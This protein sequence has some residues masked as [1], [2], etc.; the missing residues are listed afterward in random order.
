MEEFNVSTNIIRDQDIAIQY[1]PTENARANF[2]LIASNYKNN[3]KFQGIIG[4]YGTG[5]SSFL[6]AF[7]QNLLG[8]KKYFNSINSSY[9]E[10]N[11]FQFIKLIGEYRSLSISLANTLKIKY[12]EN[13]AEN[14]EDE[15]IDKL[16]RI[17]KKN[18]K[19]N[20][21]TV[22][23]LDE[24][25][26]F[27]EFAVKNNPDKEVY[28]IQ[29]L[30]E[31]F[32]DPNKLALSI[33]SLH[34]NF[35]SYGQTLNVE[36]FKEWEKVKGRFKEVPFNEPID[37]LLDFASKR[38]EFKDLKLEDNSLQLFKLLK[39]HTVSDKKKKIDFSLAEELLPLDYI[40]AEIMAKS[41]QRYGQN[42]RSLFSFLDIDER[43][44]FKWFYNKSRN[45]K[46]IPEAYNL[47]L[48]FDYIFEHYYFVIAS[49]SNTDLTHW[50]AIKSALDQVDTRLGE[51][52]ILYGRQIVK[53][54]G[55]LNIFTHS[56]ANIDREFISS[57][58]KLALGINFPDEIIDTLVN[59]KI[60][61]YKNYKHRFVFTD[62]TDLDIDNELQKAAIKIED[63]KNVAERVSGLDNFYPILV[64]SHYFKSGTPRVFEYQ[65]TNTMIQEI[66]LESDALIN[67]V[68]SEEKINI[69]K[70]TKPV[71]YAVF[72]NTA[73]I[74]SLFYEID[75]AKKVKED[76]R[77]DRSAIRE[78]E[79]RIF[80]NEQELKDLLIEDVFS[81]NNIQ[82]YYQG[83]QIS[84]ENKSQFNKQLN[85]VLEDHYKK[86]PIFRSE[87]VNKSKLS[88]PISTARKNLIRE[89]IANRDKE[90][91]GF[92]DDKFPPEKTIYLSLIRSL[93]LHRLNNET[94]L[95][96]LGAPDF[97]TKNKLINSFKPLWDISM[98]F[99]EKSKTSK[100]NVKDFYEA[101]S[102]PPLKLKR[103]FIDFWVPI[104]LIVKKEDYALFNENGYIPNIDTEVFDV[105]YKSPQKFW[106]KA[107]D[108]SGVKLEV[109]N[110]YK[111]ILNRKK[112]EKASEQDFINTIKPF[113]IFTRTLNYYASNTKKLTQQSIDL[114]EAIKNAKD[115][116]KAFFEDFPKA[117]NYEEALQ[118]G[119]EKMLE[120]FVK[121][122]E[123]SI[124]EI[125][126]S[127]GELLTRFEDKINDVLSEKNNDFKKYQKLLN[128]RLNSID[129]S[130]LNSRL[131]N[132]YRKCI[133]PTTDRKLF[134][135]G[136][137]YA[138]L[139]KGL[140]KIKDEEEEILYKDFAT[141]YI[142][143]LE[144]VDI[145]KLKEVHK[146]DAV[147]GIKIFN[148]GGK[149]LEEKVIIP[150][151]SEGLIQEE[152]VKIDKSFNGLDVN[153]KKA[154]LIELL[155]KEMNE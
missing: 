3:S 46:T 16:G 72:K 92:S 63:I 1:I 98:E 133:N 55:L 124:N 114:R 65:F 44:S 34:Q 21:A 146:N 83:V 27:L 105:M 148:E 147:F 42:E 117:L 49:K 24:F 89:L 104:F 22:L 154:V 28:F 137:A 26:K 53:T 113:I 144:L 48:V 71:I 127:Y 54:I 62:W 120:G 118:K 61:V 100:K 82:W 142:H 155:K 58:A 84:I 40:S 13:E 76:N 50:N 56:G 136:V 80:Y 109:F 68:F 152:L 5:K 77:E 12:L 149:D 6:W 139:G 70:I 87:L 78:L 11:S 103:G 135:E 73:T 41:L 88:T 9:P 111:T 66:P 4:S 64:K 45:D 14:I 57:Y 33:S 106:V 38:N 107:F 108:I 59:Q 29:R 25:G 150:F 121:K 36:Q 30:A 69:T 122:M 132:I 43:F 125:R 20:I 51:K 52:H 10:V 23:L 126:K 90:N 32:N 102:K 15:V 86:S 134:L 47:S 128:L 60:I 99:I 131:R 18:S 115:P 17:I 97:K 145:H 95:F 119:D 79:E 35:S 7:E 31:F 123:D 143:L 81:N 110:K 39:K 91:I 153:L 151:H 94:E 75:K 116:E 141:N 8:K 67:Y 140:D 74:K 96:E 93:R 101:L 130:L 138:V 112:T 129:G 85:S 2:N 19:K 37:Q